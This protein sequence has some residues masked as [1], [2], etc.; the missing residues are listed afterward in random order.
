MYI[1]DLFRIQKNRFVWMR[2]I[3]L[4]KMKG[5]WHNNVSHHYN[6]FFGID[7]FHL[8]VN[9]YFVYQSNK[10]INYCLLQ[11][12]FNNYISCIIFHSWTKAGK[13]KIY[14]KVCCDSISLCHNASCTWL[15]NNLCIYWFRYHHWMIYLASA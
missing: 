8:T 14:M 5:I 11:N 7:G 9:F 12:G 1:F 3:C 10:M 6:L 13:W 4:K 2:V 15:K